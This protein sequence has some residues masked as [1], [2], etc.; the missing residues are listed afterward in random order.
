MGEDVLSHLEDASGNAPSQKPQ[1][2]APSRISHREELQEE[3]EQR[4][5]RQAVCIALKPRLTIQPCGMPQE[6]LGKTVVTTSL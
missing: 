2:R 6:S 1:N 5:G 3:E 4:T